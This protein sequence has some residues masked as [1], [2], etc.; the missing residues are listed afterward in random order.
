[1]IKYKAAINDHI[2]NDCCLVLFPQVG[3]IDNIGCSS[4]TKNK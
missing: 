2:E 4:H 3:H 1:M